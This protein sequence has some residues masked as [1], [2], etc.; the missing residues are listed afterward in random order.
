MQSK[1]T[2]IAA[3]STAACLV[4]FGALAM[5][6][7]PKSKA[8]TATASAPIIKTQVSTTRR[9]MHIKRKPRIVVVRAS[10]SGAATP[11]ATAASYAAVPVQQTSP[12][13]AQSAAPTQIDPTAHD[14]S[15]GEPQDRSAEGEDSAPQGGERES[16]DDFQEREFEGDD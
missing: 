2:L 6:S 5:S 4:A 9:V 11:R 1:K 3:G 13:R 15:R 10:S 8:G 7:Q 12:S 16:H 14:D